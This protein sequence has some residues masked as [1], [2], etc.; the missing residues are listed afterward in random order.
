MSRL[1]DHVLIITLASGAV[2]LD[3]GLDFPETIS[4]ALRGE[5]SGVHTLA[6]SHRVDAQQEELMLQRSFD[7]RPGGAL[8][9]DV[10]DAD[11]E[12]QTGSGSGVEVKLYLH[13]EDMEWAR[14]MYERAGFRA[15]EQGSTVRLTSQEV[16]VDRRDWGRHRWYSVRASIRIPR[17][18]DVTIRTGDGD[19]TVEDLD[20]SLDLRTADGDVAVGRVSGVVEAHTQDGDVIVGDIEGLRVSVRSQ[21]GDLSMG[22]LAVEEAVIET[23]DGDVSVES[24]SGEVRVHTHDGDLRIG[25]TSV[26]G[27]SIRTGDGDVTVYLPESFA[28]D[29]DIQSESIDVGDA[30]QV[31]GSVSQHRIKGALNGGG[32]LLTVR[33]SDGSVT[34]RPASR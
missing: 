18:F 8:A 11:V 17:Q 13:S 14:R 29:V 4:S 25:L 5:W 27:A 26:E 15:E 23:Q 31:T 1:T 9:V 7:I 10:H 28:A 22:A 33:T 19:V 12:V 3:A 21:D 20:G 30:F 16:R 32:P 6:D 34:F 24:V 2:A